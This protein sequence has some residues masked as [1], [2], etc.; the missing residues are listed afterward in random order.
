MNAS[1]VHV[2]DCTIRD[3]SYAI[4][5]QFTAE[6]T[7]ILAAGLSTVG[8]SHIEVAHGL[9]LGGD[10]LNQFSSATTDVES[11]IAARKGCRGESLVGCFF[12]PSIGTHDDL[13]AAV[14]AGLDFVRIG[15]DVDRYTDME[16]SIE[17]ARSLGLE[18]W[19]N[20]MKSYIVTPEKFAIAVSD[21]ADMGAQKV[22]LVDSAGGMT[23]EQVAAY[24]DA[25]LSVTDTP[26]GFH[27]HDNLRMAV[28]NCMRFVECG[29]QFVDGSL[30]GIGRSS[31]N[32]A[33]E[34]LVALL[35]RKQLIDPA[36][37]W[38]SLLEFADEFLSFAVPHRRNTESSEAAMGLGYIHSGFEPVIQAAA[39]N[40]GTTLARTV[41]RLPAGSATSVSETVARL[42]AVAAAVEESDALPPLQ[43]R[44]RHRFSVERHEPQ[45]LAELANVLFIEKGKWLRKAVVT[46]VVDDEC[47]ELCLRPLRSTAQTLVAHIEVASVDCLPSIYTVLGEVADVWLFDQTINRA[48]WIKS[49]T[50]CYGYSDKLLSEQACIDTLQAIG[51]R[52]ILWPDLLD[53][54]AIVAR[55]PHSAMNPGEGCVDAIV[56]TRKADTVNVEHLKQVGKDGYLVI[57]SPGLVSSD[58]IDS[59]RMLGIEVVRVDYG[60]A[61][62]C[63]AERLIRTM[64]RTSVSAGAVQLSDNVS[65][66]AGG[67]VGP[68]GAFIVDSISSPRFILGMADGTGGVAPLDEA[69]N[70][71]IPK[72]QEWI[73]SHWVQSL[74]L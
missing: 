57:G 62:L 7:S 31:G 4:D 32:A 68:A 13:R 2:L 8:I 49:S 5:S 18:V 72:V 73:Y 14:D 33:T 40:E 46:V 67:T 21:L 6:D 12:I 61:L 65:I 19:G 43:T 30:G 36:I 24:T 9:G 38:E 11:I 26:L 34:L 29:G 27:G 44:Q 15:T 10:R 35:A 58:V 59:A 39:N 66:V 25:S 54:A 51:A 50:A 28:A 48:D 71:E 20:L 22:A 17:F 63:E 42:A 55:F 70:D 45:T 53:E 23:P 41:L 37:R 16:S 74:S 69:V 56:V 1:T 64:E 60:P 52:S 3:G 47:D